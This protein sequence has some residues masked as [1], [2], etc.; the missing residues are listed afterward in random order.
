MN[1]ILAISD[2]ASLELHATMLLARS[3]ANELVSTHALA[4]ELEV[5]EAHLSKVLHQ[6]LRAGLLW[7]RRGPRGGFRLG[8]SPEDITLLDVF[9]VI[10]GPLP[11]THCLL[12]RPRC[13]GQSCV[14]GGLLET[15]QETVRS[16]LSSTRLSRFRDGRPSFTSGAALHLLPS[17]EVSL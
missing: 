13:D 17:M 5:S 4:D 11:T 8:R 3:P 10:E 12:G 1:H 2:A 9:E 14:L 16:Y 15:I 7:A 6:L